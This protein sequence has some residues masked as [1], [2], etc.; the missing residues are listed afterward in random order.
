[1]TDD[2]TVQPRAGSTAHMVELPGS[3]A[4]GDQHADGEPDRKQPQH[5]G[6]ASDDAVHDVYTLPDRTSI[7]IA[8]SGRDAG[9]FVTAPV[10]ASNLLPWHGHVI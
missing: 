9:P 1:M 4:Q 3:S 7:V 6:G 10:A 2:V 8:G 5:G